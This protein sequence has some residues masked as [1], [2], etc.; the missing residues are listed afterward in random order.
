MRHS[1]EAH[2]SLPNFLFTCGVNG[3][4]QSFSKL[5]GMT[6]HLS[7]KHKGVDLENAQV[8]SDISP[9]IRAEDCNEE[10]EIDLPQCA[11]PNVHDESYKEDNL[12]RSAAL[13]L[14][15][16][17]ERFEITQSALDF[18]V[19]QV[20]QM[21]DFAFENTRESVKNAVFPH[22]QASASSQPLLDIDECIITPNPFTNLKSEYLQSKYY[23]EHFDLVVCACTK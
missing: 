7:R 19:S 16:M 8:E 20:Q 12:E 9:A 15:S 11:T 5:S 13:F 14:L 23:Q 10:M 6:S 22:L 4:L 1:F 18:A 21:I 2:S 3:C 17:K